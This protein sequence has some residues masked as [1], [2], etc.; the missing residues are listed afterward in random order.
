MIRILLSLILLF[1]LSSCENDRSKLHLYGWEEVFSKEIIAEFEKRYDTTVIFDIYDSNETMYAKLRTGASGYDLIVPT[2]Y[3]VEIM[4]KQGMLEEID[5]DQIPNVKNLDLNAIWL[6]PDN[7]KKNAFPFY[8]SYSGIGFR[9]DRITTPTIS[10]HIFN[11]KEFSRRMTLLNDI[12]EVIGAALI[13]LGFDPN[14]TN[15]EEI[16]HAKQLIINWKKHIAKF[17]NEQYKNGLA[18]GEFFLSQGYSGEIMQVMEENPKI[19][20][21]IPEEGSLISFDFFAI[22]KGAKNKDLAMKFINFMYEPEISAKN[23]ISFLERIPNQEAYPLLPEYLR[24]SHVLFP[25]EETQERLHV[26]RDLGEDI[27]LY[28]KAWEEIKE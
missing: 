2:L 12:R 22:P 27:K 21:L 3:F 4:Q 23:M 8:L 15:P 20:F 9:T 16:D 11:S 6:V 28:H 10:W 13:T 5:W 14:T 24:E 17:E 7:I 18:T 19:N 1:A 26:I 25:S